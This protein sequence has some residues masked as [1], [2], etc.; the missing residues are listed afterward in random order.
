MNISPLQTS[1]AD[2]EETKT[3]KTNSAAD[4]FESLLIAQM[5]KSSREEG[6][7]W[8]D[9][10]SDKT[11]DAAIGFGEEQ[12]AAA[13]SAAGGLG[14]AKIVKSGL[15]TPYM[16]EPVLPDSESVMRKPL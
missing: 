8:L 3:L 1:F 2:P 12:L 11:A 5:L 4:Q 14:L 16:A 7:G 10:G 13:L 9:S 6:S 15:K